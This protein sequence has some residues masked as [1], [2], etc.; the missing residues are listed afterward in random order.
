MLVNH[1]GIKA[2][3]RGRT[4]NLERLRKMLVLVALLVV[5]WLVLSEIREGREAIG[6]DD[7]STPLQREIQRQKQRLA[8]DNVEERRDAVM[9]LGNL[10][11]PEASRAAAAAL[12]DASATMRVAAAHAVGSLPPTEAASLLIPLLKDKS[13]FVRRE[14]AFALGKVREHS[15]VPP[16]IDSLH[17]KKLSVRA[18]AAIALGDIGDET[19][20]PALVQ[21][22]TGANGKKSKN[23]DE[24]FVRRSAAKALGQIRS[25]AA[26]PALIKTLQNLNAASDTRREAAIS[27][28]LI[29]DSSALPA[30]HTA[31]ESDD[32]Y[33]AETAR[34]AIKAIERVRK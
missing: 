6:Q 9:R 13:E 4:I 19:A 29:G 20:A 33:L 34:S 1:Y 14:A 21:V 25:H 11:R 23:S 24:E 17:E 7:R 32:P 10:K 18:A 2:S 28:G 3:T 15:A 26:V 12:N 16:L 30:L 31:L 5:S 8:S 27:L 22:L